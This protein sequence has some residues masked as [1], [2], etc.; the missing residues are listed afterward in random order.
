MSEPIQALAPGYLSLLGLKNRGMNPLVAADGLQPIIDMAPFY[1]ASLQQRMVGQTGIGL[2]Q[3]FATFVL[4]A[5]GAL[6][7][8]V[9]RDEVWFVHGYTVS[10]SVGA[11]ERL[12]LRAALL[13]DQVIELHTSPLADIAGASFTGAAGL[14]TDSIIDQWIPGGTFFGFIVQGYTGAARTVFGNAIVSRFK[15]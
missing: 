15:V 2:N 13:T 14:E 10:A 5:T 4:T 1:L 3:N 12:A 6:P 7:A 9:P 8:Q 11:A